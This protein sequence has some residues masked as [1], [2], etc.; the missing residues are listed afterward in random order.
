MTVIRLFLTC[1]IVYGL[2][3][4]TN[5]IPYTGT[6]RLPVV[7]VDKYAGMHCDIFEK[8]GQGWHIVN[9][10]GASI[11]AVIRY[12]IARPGDRSHL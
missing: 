10:P 9:N 11:V 12:A 2:H 8:V 5:N 4:G 1:W 3:F 7:P 6:G